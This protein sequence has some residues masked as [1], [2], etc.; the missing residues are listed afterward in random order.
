METIFTKNKR[1]E[2][3]MADMKFLELLSKEFPNRKAATGEIINLRAIL[4]LPKGT[5]YFLSD[6][7]G[8]DEAFRHMITSASGTIRAKI[9]EHFGDE[10]SHEERDDL[11]ALIYNPQA[12][13]AR[14]KLDT[15]DFDS[16]CRRNI[17]SLIVICQSVSTKY[18]R[19]KVRKRLPR[20][21]GYSMDELLHADD[22]AN[23]SHY[24]SEIFSSIIESGMAEDFICEMAETISSLAVDKLHIIGDVFDRGSHPDRI[25][26]YL[27]GYHDVDFQWGNHDIAW[28]GAA[29][30]SWACITNVLRMN[31]S[32]YNFDMLE[33]GYGINL[34]PLSAFALEVYG[35]DPCE[36]FRPKIIETSQF[37]PVDPALAAKMHKAIA[38]CQFKVEGQRIKAHPE[39]H[40]EN[41]LLLDKIDYEKG[42]IEIKGKTYELRDT[43]F[44][45]IDPKDPYKLTHDE[46]RVLQNLTASI[47]RSE[48]LQKHIRF[49]FAHGA[50]Y[51]IQ[52]GNLMYHGCIPMDADGKFL[53]VTLNGSTNHGKALF[54]Y[55]DEQVRL[56]YFNPKKSEET[57]HSG[58]LMWY[59]WLGARSPMFGKDQMTTFERLFIADKATHKEHTSPYYTLINQEAI[60]DKILVEFGL[61]PETSHILSG[62][63]PV[64]IKDGE[65][66][67]K[68]GGK[69]FIIDGGIS[70][71]YQKTTGIAGY[72]FIYNSRFMALAE[73]KPYQPL[74][75]DGTQVFNAPTIRTVEVMKKRL[76][77]KDTDQG[78]D[79]QRQINDLRALL[80]AYRDGLLKEEY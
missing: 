41:R 46:E 15:A 19:S 42:T 52:N 1:K 6:L 39:Y 73:H 48:K 56:A 26:D 63:V 28:M 34:R 5:E 14:R 80:E 64:K 23:K 77:V 49:M 10:M 38:I 74:Q 47:M 33:V 3:N 67:I 78:I 17:Y 32:Y 76:T 30:G 11:A 40:L 59:L 58:D 2:N 66:P 24:Y 21:W 55:L 51:K 29:A 20:Y 68:G 8:E 72:T 25:M 4:A 37:D 62:H 9:D 79:L 45:T 71:A 61:D 69:L 36:A 43:N 54:D 22:E 16:W 75:K 60:A 18:T 50:L 65:S 57:G 7:H 13:I 70:K 31:I 53:D 27:M 12:E 35:D 44:P